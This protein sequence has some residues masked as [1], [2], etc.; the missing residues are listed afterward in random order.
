MRR[1][2]KLAF[3]LLL[4]YLVLY[5]FSRSEKINF[6][7][8]IVEKL[9][10]ASPREILYLMVSIIFAILFLLVYIVL[11][12]YFYR[13]L[14]SSFLDAIRGFNIENIGDILNRLSKSCLIKDIKI[15]KGLGTFSITILASYYFAMAFFIYVFDA[16]F[17]MIAEVSSF[18]YVEARI[19][20]LLFLLT[21]FL[22]LLLF[23]VFASEESFSEKKDN[24]EGGETSLSWL[25]SRLERYLSPTCN[26]ET[27]KGK[28]TVSLIR[29]ITPI[30][31]IPFSIDIVATPPQLVPWSIVKERFTRIMQTKE[32]TK[33]DAK[34]RSEEG[35]KPPYRLI[36]SSK[37][38]GKEEITK[39]VDI[40][41]MKR[42][43]TYFLHIAMLEKCGKP[44]GIVFFFITSH[45]SI[46]KH[47]LRSLS[48]HRA[49]VS[50]GEKEEMLFIMGLGRPDI[51]LFMYWLLL[52]FPSETCSY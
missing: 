20:T 22:L 24:S 26:N 32:D 28:V 25:H 37:I 23:A 9:P 38:N 6:S 18:S 21:M 16:I 15:T 1:R 44:L 13:R 30:P 4:V 33:R 34:N 10:Y 50:Q 47:P 43:L 46:F 41:K 5:L 31:V 19:P 52:A 40:D 17:L 27:G 48:L 39:P 42:G 45:I 14:R 29:M 11:L 7:L 8:I 36:V 12:K 49:I 35:E 51:Q 2:P 3:Q